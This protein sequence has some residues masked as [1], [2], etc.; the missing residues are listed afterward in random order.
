MVSL[1][2]NHLNGLLADEVR[3]PQLLRPA[4]AAVCMLCSSLSAGDMRAQ[5]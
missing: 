2:N 4:A 5:C 1:Y 3:C